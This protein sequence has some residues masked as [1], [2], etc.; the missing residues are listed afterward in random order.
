VLRYSSI[1]KQRMLRIIEGRTPWSERY[2]VIATLSSLFFFVKDGSVPSQI[3]Q[4]L[5]SKKLGKYPAATSGDRLKFEKLH[6]AVALDDHTANP[7]TH[8]HTHT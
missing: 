1:Q 7:H 6:V 4:V 8:T 5:A 2:I 3:W